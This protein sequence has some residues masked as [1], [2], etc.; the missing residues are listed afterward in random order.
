MTSS[1]CVSGKFLHGSYR[2][3]GYKWYV[4]SGYDQKCPVPLVVMLHG[5]T[6]NADDF[7]VGTGMNELA[8][9]NN[10]IVLYPEQ[11]K[12]A[13]YNACWNW[14]RATH[15]KR[16][17][18]EPSVI[19]GM[20]EKIKDGYSIDEKCV[21]AAGLSAGGAMSVILGVTYPDLFAG[22]G[23]CAGLEYK[24]AHHVMGAYAAMAKGGPNPV[25]QGRKAYE[26]M[27]PHAAVMP[28]IVFHGDRDETVALKNADQLTTQWAVTNDLAQD[29]RL[30]GW[31][32]DQADHIITG[33][34]P[35]GREY[36]HYIYEN[37]DGKAIMEKFIVA[38]MGHAWPGG[39]PKGSY[40]DSK[41]PDAS[42]IMWEFFMRH[43]MDKEVREKAAY[44]AEDKKSW[45]H[46]VYDFCLKKAQNKE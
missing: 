34:V 4:P 44:H 36:Q 15:Q 32:D 45:W 33:H 6:Q 31:M 37:D 13:N 21:F 30:T 5:C 41:G 26:E 39:S 28:V 8:E 27:G 14:F 17:K 19:A 9:E 40:T 16:G 18:G 1:D 43:T 23:V 29:G 46:K 2:G 42:R 24:A 3:K 7:A 38:G 12:A 25:R 22:I 20:I 11:S 35:G 10:F